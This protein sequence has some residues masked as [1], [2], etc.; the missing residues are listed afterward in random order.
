M[1]KIRDTIVAELDSYVEAYEDACASGLRPAVEEFLPAPSHPH[2]LVIAA[3]MLRVDLEL[4]WQFGTPRPLAEYRRRFADVLSDA[5]RWN[6]LA[7]EEFRLRLQAGDSVAPTEYRD[8]HGVDTSKWPMRGRGQDETEGDGPAVRRT[9]LL[10][11]SAAPPH[12]SADVFDPELIQRAFPNFVLVNELGRGSFGCVYLAREQ[13]LAGRFVALKVAAGASIEPE[14]LAQLQHANIVPVYSVHQ[15]AGLQGICMPF[16]GRCTLADVVAR[17]Q[18]HAETPQSGQDLL[19]TIVA[20]SDS[21]VASPLKVSD[22]QR[23]AEGEPA[24]RVELVPSIRDQY[25]RTTYV[26][27][28][29]WIGA[30]MAA[31]LA[32]AHERGILHR[33]LKPANVLLADDGRPMLLDFNLADR[34][35]APAERAEL[36]GGTIP[37][38]SPEQLEALETG[39]GLD[40]RC[41]VFSL[42]VVL[43]ELLT[44]QLPFP[45]AAPESACPTMLA[46]QRRMGPP[47][48]RQINPAI[49]RSL[50][51]VVARCLAP[52]PD[53]RY[54]SA[55]ELRC[56]LERH[57]ANQPLA[58]AP[59]HYLPERCAKWVRRHPRLS[60]AAGLAT[61]AATLLVCVGIAWGIR[62]QRVARVEAESNFQAFVSTAPTVEAPLSV[63][64]S[65]VEILDEGIRAA[66]EQIA[67]Y[68]VMAGANW[69]AGSSYA[70]LAPSHQRAVDDRLATTLYLLS[71]AYQRRAATLSSGE[72]RQAALRL[73]TDVNALAAAVAEQRAGRLNAAIRRQHAKLHSVTS[74]AADAEPADWAQQSPTTDA[75]LEPI[76]LLTQGRYEAALPRLIEWRDRSPTDLTAWL[77]L[78][79]AYAGVGAA[80]DAEECYTAAIVQ[81]PD[82][83]YSHFLRGLA[84]YEV[85]KYQGAVD[86]FTVVL[87]LGGCPL[88]ARVNR[89]LALY[90]AKELDEALA[91]LDAALEH[92][93]APV[94]LYFV[95]AQVRRERGDAAG[96]MRDFQ[97]G[98]RET[99]RDAN[100]WIT[101]G[102]AKLKIDAAAALV[103]FHHALELDPG[104]RSAMQNIVHV[105]ADK[106]DREREALPLLDRMVAANSRDARAR[107]SRA[108]VHARLG[109]TDAALAD[110]DAATGASHDPKLLIQAAGVYAL[111]AGEDSARV[112]KGLALLA[113]AVGA[114]PSLV[115]L[116]ASDPDLTPFHAHAEFERIL[117][118][119][120]ILQNAGG[121]ASRSAKVP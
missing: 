106:L 2:F 45:A 27:A 76:E 93:A 92:P 63:P 77:L 22:A 52:R 5:Q 74:D 99:P 33:D 89:A 94:R 62:E 103:D 37:Y 114:D 35:R 60:S 12:R 7:Y 57:L 102:M 90:G 86:D 64:G 4:S 95:R 97:Q 87:K 16:L 18:M 42:G 9:P 13:E 36:V 23:T 81:R 59:D 112:E 48:A 25:Q 96:A 38:M 80:A 85:H 26:D 28:V 108:M 69:R 109:H 68:G 19:S 29:V 73:A 43:F 31:G 39:Q 20:H 88:A 65:D 3:E 105:L 53:D 116:A 119:A 15:A 117:G 32:H 55:E 11:R 40:A 98:L 66:E 61:A 56:D 111:V 58:H 30:Q 120:R 14:R 44:R 24:V 84:R 34:V 1:L 47:S 104:S 118:S 82:F 79:N 101:R 41:D 50:D 115:E 8:Q 78:G 71:G 110:V 121:G 72:E 107:A 54:Q 6:S 46:A 10:A 21:T 49:A 67:R 75:E 113:R 100:S 51:G 83:A 70:R 17:L 91:D